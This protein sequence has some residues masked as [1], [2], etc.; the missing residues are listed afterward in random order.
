[1][2]VVAERRGQR[3]SFS[4]EEHDALSPEVLLGAGY[5]FPK[6]TLRQ[7]PSGCVQVER[8]HEREGRGLM[9]AL[10]YSWPPT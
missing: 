4:I 3:E 9:A 2:I 7:Y 8:D 5:R 6:L 1:M 10:V